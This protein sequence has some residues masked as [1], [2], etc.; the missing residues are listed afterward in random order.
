MGKEQT[1]RALS[2][3]G[4]VYSSLA[5]LATGVGLAVLIWQLIWNGKQPRNPHR[6]VP[7]DE[8]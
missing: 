4:Y 5:G 2:P 7:R 1:T 3:L 6:S 8:A